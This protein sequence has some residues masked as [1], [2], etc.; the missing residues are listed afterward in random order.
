V[1]ARRPTRRRWSASP[2]RGSKQYRGSPTAKRVKILENPNPWEEWEPRRV[3]RA[4]G[5]DGRR[6]HTRIIVP[7]RGLT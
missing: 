6:V 2:R 4:P 5:R 3:V 7:P 1:T